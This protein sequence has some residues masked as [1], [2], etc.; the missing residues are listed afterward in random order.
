MIFFLLWFLGFYLITLF[1]KISGHSGVATLGAF[2]VIQLF[3]LA[4]WPVFLAIPLVSWA[5]V[6]RRDHTVGQV[7]A[8]VGY[9]IVFLF[10]ASVMC[11]CVNVFR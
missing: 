1:W 11:Q 7:I 10:G 6:V 3:G 5:R 9:S 8:G 4:W 2:F